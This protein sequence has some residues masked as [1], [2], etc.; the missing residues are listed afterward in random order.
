MQP[1]GMGII[2]VNINHITLKNNKVTIT[3]LDKECRFDSQSV[4]KLDEQ[5]T[6]PPRLEQPSILRLLRF[7]LSATNRPN[8]SLHFIVEQQIKLISEKHHS[9]VNL[10]SM[11]IM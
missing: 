6:K 10:T 3:I 11:L 2:N 5:R 1:Q 8:S 4:D 9:L 7:L